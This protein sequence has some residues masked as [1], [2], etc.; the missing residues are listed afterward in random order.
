MSLRF[1]QVERMLHQLHAIGPGK[2]AAFRSR[3]QHIQRLGFPAG[4][5]T[6][7]GRPAAYSAGQIMSLAI[8]VELL[9]LG[10]SPERAVAALSVEDFPAAIG[11]ALLKFPRTDGWSDAFLLFQ[12][13]SLAG[14]TEDGPAGPEAAFTSAIFLKHDL[15]EWIGRDGRFSRRVTIVNLS[16]IIDMVISALA[17]DGACSEDEF[18]KELGGWVQ[19]ADGEMASG[20]AL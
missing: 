7:R 12:P 3:L 4:A 16:E 10:M 6:G 18:L 17:L 8:A 1:N 11:L 13:N 19:Q 14:L 15:R 20:D 2:H 5:N 9:Q